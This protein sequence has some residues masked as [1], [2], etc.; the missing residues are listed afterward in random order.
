MGKKLSTGAHF[1]RAKARGWTDQELADFTGRSKN[2]IQKVIRGGAKAENLFETARDLGKGKRKVAPPPPTPA[3][4]KTARKK[5][6]QAVRRS[7]ERRRERARQYLKE[8]EARKDPLARAERKLDK[9]DGTDRYLI[10]VQ[11]K[12][13]GRS[14]TLCR[15]GGVSP[16]TIR[17]A[18]SLDA[19]ISAQAGNQ[20]YETDFDWSDVVEI[21]F[22]E[23]Y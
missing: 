6:A 12:K 8:R 21:E 18:P 13:T 15:K 9:L 1:S 16:D 2:Y 17:S 23:Y 3:Q 14:F 22:E 5:G 11:S 4:V 10:H 19:F 20:G 7:D